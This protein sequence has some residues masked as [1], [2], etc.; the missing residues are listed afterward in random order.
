M[1]KPH[2]FKSVFIVGLSSVLALT[3]PEDDVVAQELSSAFQSKSL[4]VVEIPEPRQG[5]LLHL[6]GIAGR[7][8][9]VFN[10]DG[11]C[12]E[13]PVRFVAGDFAGRDPGERLGGAIQILVTSPDLV[14]ELMAG[15]DFVSDALRVGT[16]PNDGSADVIIISGLLPETGFV[17]NPGRSVFADVF[18]NRPTPIIC[19][20]NVSP[21][22]MN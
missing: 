1:L 14:G 4:A 2:S 11:A 5:H 22:A 12:S 21:K 16:D 3:T 8:T 18:P 7:G 15:A 9:I 10:I 19:E 13:M 17:L 20:D 6:R